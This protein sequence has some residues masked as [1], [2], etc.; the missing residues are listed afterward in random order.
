MDGLILTGG[1][2]FVFI[3]SAES[4]I[5][6]SNF[7]SH[8]IF[9]L[10]KRIFI[11]PALL[12]FSI[13]LISGMIR[14]NPAALFLPKPDPATSGWRKPAF[15]VAGHGLGQCPCEQ[16]SHKQNVFESMTFAKGHSFV[17]LLH[18]INPTE[19]DV[20]TFLMR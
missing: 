12:C 15:L 1:I 16:D 10:E 19:P 11:S 14:W 18:E 13:I 8:G 3:Y 2:S 5:I 6:V 9:F 7:Q 20:V 4:D 17:R